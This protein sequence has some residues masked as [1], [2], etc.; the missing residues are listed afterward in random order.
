MKFLFK[1]TGRDACGHD[2]WTITD[3]TDFATQQNYIDQNGNAKTIWPETET[4]II[5][6]K[7][8][9]IGGALKI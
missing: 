3:H 2:E 4:T 8:N 7:N 5:T 1:I 9:G 6:G